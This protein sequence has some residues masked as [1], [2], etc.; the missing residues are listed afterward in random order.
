MRVLCACLLLLLLTGCA[1]FPRQETTS[2]VGYPNYDTTPVSAKEMQC[3]VPG[4]WYQVRLPEKDGRSLMVRGIFRNGYVGRLQECDEN[5]LTLTDV[6]KC[7]DFDSTSA[8]RHLPLWGSHFENGCGGCKN[9][10]APVTVRRTQLMWFEPISVEKAEPFRRFDEIMN[11]SFD[12]SANSDSTSQNA[13][14]PEMSP[15]PDSSFLLP[16][17]ER[18]ERLSRRRIE[19]L[20]MQADQWYFVAMRREERGSPENRIAHL[21]LV[22]QV[23]DDSITLTNVTTQSESAAGRSVETSSELKLPR[24]QIEYVRQET[25]EQAAEL[26]AEINESRE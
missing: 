8:L 6:T 15:F 4:E 23:N 3:L 25:P 24:S 20:E 12:L 9:E 10:S 22:R 7:T 19:I 14:V 26:I 18:E 13:P 21:G 17:P 11:T 16:N 1:M 5:S 2:P